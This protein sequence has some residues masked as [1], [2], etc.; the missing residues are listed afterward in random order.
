MHSYINSVNKIMSVGDKVKTK[1]SNNLDNLDDIDVTSDQRNVAKCST[2]PNH[3]QV[4]HDR[5]MKIENTPR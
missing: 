1:L 2:P 3:Y 5:P 4:T